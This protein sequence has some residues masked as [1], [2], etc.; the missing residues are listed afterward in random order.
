[1]NVEWG[2]DKASSNLRKCGI[3][4]ANAVI[5]LEDENTL[6]IEGNFHKELRFKT[7]GRGLLVIR[8]ERDKKTVR[9]I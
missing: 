8:T 9:I 1:M 5:A 3:D 2:P 4:F 6:T 7:L